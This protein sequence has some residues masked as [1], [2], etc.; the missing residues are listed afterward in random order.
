MNLSW[1][2]WSIIIVAVLGLRLVS[3]STRKHMKGVADFLSANRSA[4]RYLLTIASQMG[5][6]GAI[7]IVATFE[8]CYTAGFSPLWWVQMN[9]I[10]LVAIALTGWA[11]YRF[12]ETRALT[13]AQFLEMRYSRRFRVFAGIL[14]WTS[15]VLNFGI[16]PAVAARFFVY[17]CGL[18]EYFHIPGIP[19]DISTFATVML[20]DLGLA[21]TFVTMGGQISIM[22][23]ECVQGIISCIGFL[24]I[25]A[26]VLLQFKWS[27]IVAGLNMAPANASMIHPFHTS[28]VGDFGIA[29]FLIAAFSTFYGYMSWQGSAGFNCAARTPHEGKMGQIIAGWRDLVKIPMLYMLP[30]A[31]FVV[32]H[33]PQYSAQADIINATVAKISNPAIQDQM[34]VPVAL[35][36]ILPIGVKGL[37]ACLMLFF[38]FTCHD[39][40]MH[41]WGSIF[42]QDVIMPLRKKRLSPEQHIA[43]LKWSI[44]GVA[45]FAFIFSLLYRPT[46]QILMFFA[47]TGTIWLG[48][49]GAVIIGGLSWRRGTTAGAYSAII[50]GATLGILGLILPKI[51]ESHYH[52]KFPVTLQVVMFIAMMLGAVVYV[53]V[54]LATGGLKRQFN[55]ERMLH[56]GQYAIEGHTLPVE[57]KNRLLRLVGITD[58]FSRGDRIL[59]VSV[60]CW[61]LGWIALFCVVTAINV[62]QPLSN[63]WW[64]GFWKVFMWSYLAIGVPVTVWFTVGGI[65]DIRGLY[66]TLETSVRDHTDDGRVA[67]EP[68]PKEAVEAAAGVSE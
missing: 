10:V 67:V 34:R 44:I 19:L 57:H 47:I 51:Y 63:Q 59:A 54:S 35:A 4:G 9:L 7:S 55:L 48:G 26:T 33:L 6:T 64:A 8:M 42:I 16:F 58:E 1:I 43:W 3:L 50:V 24:I 49:S 36:Q 46:E 30:M 27:E 28:K 31:A 45:V 61:N 62:I 39:T 11:F 17:Y 37:F 52:V 66:R 18:P 53:L 56:R 14:C 12:R 40:Y 21:V 65:M 25:G 68:V 32:L 5:G 2:D 60:V 38:S 41:S 15:G 20:L 29:Y 22:V 23:T 13:M